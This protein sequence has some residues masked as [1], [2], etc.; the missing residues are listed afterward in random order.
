MKHLSI[1]WD[2]A[3]IWIA[4]FL[5][6]M[7]MVNSG[8]AI[9]GGPTQDTT[10]TQCADGSRCPNPYVCPAVIGHRCEAPGPAPTAWGAPRAGDA[11]SSP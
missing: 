3:I 1:L 4:A 6:G 10:T 5:L 9:L 2:Y 11:G 7:A 8:C